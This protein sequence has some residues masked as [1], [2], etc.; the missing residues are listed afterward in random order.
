MSLYDQEVYEGIPTTQ[1]YQSFNGQIYMGG[2]PIIR[3]SRGTF[4]TSQ[5]IRTYYEVSKRHGLPYHGTFTVRGSISRAYINGAEWR[6]AIGKEPG[7]DFD[8]GKV[9]NEGEL[10][11]LFG[12][13]DTWYQGGGVKNVYPIKT[14]M[15]YEVN[16]RDMLPFTRSV[17]EIE[18]VVD[19]PITSDGLMHIATIRGAIIDSSQIRIG[20]AGDLITSGPIDWIGETVQFET[21]VTV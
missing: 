18:G 1:M 8:P 9:Y 6:L 3:V 14:V 7:A 15:R 19:D 21:G 4:T 2:Y 5:G 12:E 11:T 16:N 13:D 17:S 10:V 20:Q